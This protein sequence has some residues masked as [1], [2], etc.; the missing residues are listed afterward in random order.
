MRFTRVWRSGW[1]VMGCR[2]GAEPT[3]SPGD[4]DGG[5]GVTTMPTVPTRPM[6]I[7]GSVS[8]PAIESTAPDATIVATQPVTTTAS[9]SRHEGSHR[10][11]TSQSTSAR[12][13]PESN[14]AL[15]AVLSV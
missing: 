7:T 1:L 15:D 6:I 4:H 2:H 8:G 9:S 11:P 12:A 3:G 5:T 13:G 10:R 14:A